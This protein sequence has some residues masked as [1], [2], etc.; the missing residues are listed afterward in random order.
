MRKHAEAADRSLAL[1]QAVT[2]V[3]DSIHRMYQN[4]QIKPGNS[5][6]DEDFAIEIRIP[7]ILCVDEVLD[8]CHME[9]IKAE[10][11]FDICILP[12]VFCGKRAGK[13]G[14]TQKNGQHSPEVGA[15]DVKTGDSAAEKEAESSAQVSAE[16]VRFK[17]SP[18]ENMTDHSEPVNAANGKAE[19]SPDE[20]RAEPSA[21]VSAWA[22]KFKDSPADDRETENPV[23]DGEIRKQYDKTENFAWL[24]LER[25]RIRSLISACLLLTVLLFA[26]GFIIG[27][28][29]YFK[30]SRPVPVAQV[31]LPPHKETRV[32]WH[33]E[34]DTGAVLKV[35]KVSPDILN[36]DMHVQSETG[37]T[38]PP[39]ETPKTVLPEKGS[40]QPFTLRLASYRTKE[41]ALRGLVWFQGK[42]L[43]PYL[44]KID[45]GA[46]GGIWWSVYTGHY[47]TQKEAEAARRAL[48]VSGAIIKEMPYTNFVGLFSNSA[49]TEDISRRIESVTGYRPYSI[50]ENSGKIRLFAGSFVTRESAEELNTMLKNNGIRAEVLK[51]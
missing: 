42:Q 35:R 37:E 49:E 19:I 12:K 10:E 31:S 30:T 48:P 25:K 38:V 14:N 16:T 4:I 51:R 21:A 44:I 7:D 6:E 26:A 3:T 24:V 33:P 39:A 47:P 41:D 36:P 32:T 15:A 20:N 13:T 5:Y 40:F 46:S 1:A 22:V 28:M 23:S 29:G 9:C 45:W 11:E 8:K 34:P 2:K 17:D 18:A 27:Y 43:S 50:A